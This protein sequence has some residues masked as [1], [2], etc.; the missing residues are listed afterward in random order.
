MA[1]TP[2]TWAT[3]DL[4]TAQRLNHIESGVQEV[5]SS[6]TPTTW[7][8][9]D[10]ITATKLNNIEQGIAN[11]GMPTEQ[12][13]ISITNQSASVGFNGIEWNEQLGTNI[14]R[15]LTSV[16]AYW[17]EDLW[18]NGVTSAD[19]E[20]MLLSEHFYL[21]VN[22]AESVVVT[23]NATTEYYEEDNQYIITVTGDCTITVA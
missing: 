2:T 19:V 5:S 6:Y 9:G 4:I 18:Y 13:S 23:G 20:F 15:A 7:A 10:V 11:A 14:L 16:G 21:M 1:Y 12:V 3:G 17:A 22:N 8:T